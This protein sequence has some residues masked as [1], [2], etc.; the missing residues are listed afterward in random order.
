MSDFL[1]KKCIHL[2]EIEDC[3]ICLQRERSDNIR[4]SMLIALVTGAVCALVFVVLG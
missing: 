4:L 1:L 3:D 2:R